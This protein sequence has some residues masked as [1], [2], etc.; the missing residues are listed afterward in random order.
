MK[1]DESPRSVAER[2]IR[3]DTKVQ[4]FHQGAWTSDEM[5]DAQA[6][7]DTPQ[8][9]EP[10]TPVNTTKRVF[11]AEI[12]FNSPSD[13]NWSFGCEKD[14]RDSPSTTS[15]SST[16]MYSDI[17]LPPSPLNGGFGEDVFKLSE[18]NDVDSD[19]HRNATTIQSAVRRMRAIKQYRRIRIKTLE[20]GIAG[21][22]WFAATKIQSFYRSWHCRM[23]L[24]VAILQKR[25]ARSERRKEYSLHWIEENKK[26]EMARF[27]RTTIMVVEKNL[28]RSER[29][30]LKQQRDT[31]ELRAENK[32]LR[33]QN[34]T[35]MEANQIQEDKQDKQQKQLNTYV[36]YN[37]MLESRTP[38]LQREHKA[39]M[40]S[41]GAFEERIK[42][43]E[44][45]V[46]Q[47]VE[48]AT[49]E[50]K[51][52]ESTKAVILKVLGLVKGSTV[53][54]ELCDRVVKMGMDGL[55]KSDQYA[56]NLREL[57]A[58]KLL[59]LKEKKEQAGET[60]EALADVP[61]ETE[62]N[63]SDSEVN[64]SEAS[65][66]EVE[67]GE[68]KELEKTGELPI[69]S[70][71]S[72]PESS[73]PPKS[74]VLKSSNEANQEKK[75][76]TPVETSEG[77][78]ESSKPYKSSTSKS[79][80]E[81][82]QKKVRVITKQA[83]K[84]SVRKSTAEPAAGTKSVSKR[85]LREPTA[86]T[87]GTKSH[88]MV[89]QVEQATGTSPL[90][91]KRSMKNAFERPIGGKSSSKQTYEKLP[92]E[93]PESKSARPR[94]IVTRAEVSSA[95]KPCMSSS[96][97]YIRETR[98]RKASIKNDIKKATFRLQKADAV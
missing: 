16:T 79:P 43:F 61:E 10:R 60:T 59:K 14:G 94:S 62:L 82:N 38:Q 29:D 91:K 17:M 32:K 24:R 97:K 85:S 58:E 86:Q 64:I 28:A 56:E 7:I 57:T 25:L 20:G 4:E 69:E 18:Y 3:F 55:A 1:T 2:F 76:E 68:K 88:A 74:F 19:E 37:A 87:T 65:E 63:T 6:V 80:N 90:I 81:V 8:D 71:E 31:D 12:P 44:R 52:Q 46:S 93:S 21:L 84:R 77:Q 30:L 95:T 51:I 45:A 89:S 92:Q 73:K 47:A 83:S 50:K 53:D 72:E 66:D 36:R 54:K 11:I 9:E 22:R 5:A 41:V 39:I 49:F 33:V 26:H 34:Q 98:D 13:E 35:L 27:D 40:N 15:C 78:A 96:N 67:I 48:F 75:K 23:L 42:E 70:S